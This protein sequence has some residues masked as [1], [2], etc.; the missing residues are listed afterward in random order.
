[1]ISFTGS[2]ESIS[3]EGN[4]EVYE[5]LSKVRDN[6][7]YEFIPNY[8][9]SKLFDNIGN[10]AGNFTFSSFGNRKLFETNVLESKVVNDLSYNANSFLFDNVV[11]NNYYLKFVV[12]EF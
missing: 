11:T 10:L 5:D 6:D 7:R 3:L 1:M 2:S 4:I 12:F 9:F 8:R